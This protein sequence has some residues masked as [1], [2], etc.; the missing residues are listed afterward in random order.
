MP[1]VRA[2]GAAPLSDEQ[3]KSLAVSASECAASAAIADEPV[4]TATPTLASATASPDPRATTTV[5]MLSFGMTR[6]PGS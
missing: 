4:N 1:V 3:E 2:A 5:R 6:P